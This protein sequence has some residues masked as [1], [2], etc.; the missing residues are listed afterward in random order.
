MKNFKYFTLAILSV[1]FISEALKAA[2]P[3]RRAPSRTSKSSSKTLEAN[4][5]PATPIRATDTARNSLEDMS[6]QEPYTMTSRRQMDNALQYMRS[7]GIT[8]EQITETIRR[9]YRY[10]VEDMKYH[11]LFSYFL[12]I[13]SVSAIADFSTDH[14]NNPLLLELMKRSLRW[15][16]NENIAQDDIKNELKGVVVDLARQG[17]TV[18]QISSMLVKTENFYDFTINYIDVTQKAPETASANLL[19]GLKPEDIMLA[20]LIKE[21]LEEISPSQIQ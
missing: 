13:Q 8:E 9:G 14:I 4:R 10:T 15:A 18:D 3:G 19:E 1:F 17:T 16:I 7:Q 2:P 5:L 6:T 11:S 12:R 21:V 20:R